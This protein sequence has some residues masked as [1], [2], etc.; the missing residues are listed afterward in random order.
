M[1]ILIIGGHG[2]IGRKVVA[3][4]SMEHE[5]ITAGRNSGDIT[6]DISD[7]KSIQSTFG[8]TGM[9]DAIICTA[10]EAKWAPFKDLSEEDFYI[11]L[12]S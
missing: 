10:G 4:F 2:T 3:H 1:K 9:V 8:Q 5:V 6:I 12:R 11:G 7:S